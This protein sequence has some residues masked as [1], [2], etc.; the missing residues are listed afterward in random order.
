MSHITDARLKVKD[1]DALQ[2]AAE[3][4]GLELVRDVKRYNWF[5]EFVGDSAEGRR[6]AAER[7]AESFGKCDHVL[8]RKGAGSSDYE[9]GVVADST[10]TAFDLLYDTWG[11]G[12]KL[13]TAAGKGLHRLRQEYSVA[14]AE[15][16]VTKTLGR[17]GFR[18]TRENKEGGRIQLRLRRR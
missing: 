7:G 16:R 1:L 17:Q 2:A 5:G 11:S 9:I 10:G 6:V 13:E 3:T 8:R 15:A 4:L 12:A 18:M 14:V